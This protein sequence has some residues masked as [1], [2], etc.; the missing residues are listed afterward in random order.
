MFAQTKYRTLLI[1][2]M[3]KN[4][5]WFRFT[6]NILPLIEIRA[7]ICAEATFWKQ[8]PTHLRIERLSIKIEI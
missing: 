5:P 6:E 7:R 3:M 8:V 4:V 1:N 2:E